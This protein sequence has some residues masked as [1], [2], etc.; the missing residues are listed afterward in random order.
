MVVKILST[1]LYH[2]E[3]GPNFAEPPVINIPF[4]LYNKL[5]TFKNESSARIG[6]LAPTPSNHFTYEAGRYTF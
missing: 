6:T 1:W 2:Y 3:F 4:K 5:F